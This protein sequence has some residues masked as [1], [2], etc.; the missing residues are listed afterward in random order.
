MKVVQRWL[1]H[2]SAAVMLGA[3]ASLCE[4]DLHLLRERMHGI[5][6]AVMVYVLEDT[7]EPIVTE[8]AMEGLPVQG[9]MDRRNHVVSVMSERRLAVETPQ[10]RHR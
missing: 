5:V 2:V 10:C 7:N 1:G 4:A 9:L 8:S 6:G 3:Y